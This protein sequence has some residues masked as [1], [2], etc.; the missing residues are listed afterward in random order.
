[1]R[2]R[3]SRRLEVDTALDMRARLRRLGRE[4]SSSAARFGRVIGAET[5]EN[6]LSGL[7]GVRTPRPPSAP[8]VRRVARSSLAGGEQEI[9]IADALS[10]CAAAT[11][12]RDVIQ[13]ADRGISMASRNGIVGGDRALRAGCRRAVLRLDAEAQHSID[14][15]APTRT[16]LRNTECNLEMRGQGVPWARTGEMLRPW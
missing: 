3:G 14:V 4:R 9:A 15:L 7:F 13:R 11:E 12:A 2:A 1:M 16:G 5:N 8:T 10:S 6:G